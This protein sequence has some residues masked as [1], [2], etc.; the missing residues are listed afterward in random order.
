MALIKKVQHEEKESISVRIGVELLSRVN[1]YAEYLEGSREY[2][3]SE[4]LKAVLKEAD[5]KDPEWAA[6]CGRNG[7]KWAKGKVA[8]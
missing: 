4:A 5:A 8:G 6:F 1:C 2:V 3:I 7:A